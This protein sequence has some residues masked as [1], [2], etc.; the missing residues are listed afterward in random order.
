MSKEKIDKSEHLACI[1]MEVWIRC[2]KFKNLG[3]L[4]IY[5]TETIKL[6]IDR[7]CDGAEQFLTNK[8]E[9]WQ[10]AYE[11]AYRDINQEIC[12]YIFSTGRRINVSIVV[13]IQRRPPIDYDDDHKERMKK[14][15][16]ELHT[17]N[18]LI[19]LIYTWMNCVPE[20]H[21]FDFK[22]HLLDAI[23]ECGYEKYVPVII[24]EMW[25]SGY[26][27][28]VWMQCIYS[29]N[30]KS[31]I[32]FEAEQ[33][34]VLWDEIVLRY[35]I[36]CCTDI[37]HVLNLIK[38]VQPPFNWSKV[39]KNIFTIDEDGEKSSDYTEIRNAVSKKYKE[40][41]Q[42]KIDLKEW[43][44]DNVFTQNIADAKNLSQIVV[45]YFDYV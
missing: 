37:N 18:T 6:I 19:R 9:F 44:M 16:A 42:Q 45:D 8:D 20:Y 1:F 3:F 17:K 22:Q 15:L 10:E 33:I 43:F 34:G 39:F 7:L 41:K 27:D 24:K 31:R 4:Y 23:I 28:F 32:L 21:A 30:L 12:D 29:E 5:D 25:E 14:L 38:H 36:L 35:Y 26:N 40:M 13:D 2:F 11:Y